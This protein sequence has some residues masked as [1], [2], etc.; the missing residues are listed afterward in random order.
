MTALENV[1]LALSLRDCPTS[2][3]TERADAALVLVTLADRAGQRVSRLS[4]G[5]S[6]RVA[7]AGALACAR[8]LLIADE[9]TSRLDEDNATTVAI[10]LCEAAAEGQ[11]VICAT[12][13]P[14]LIRYAERVVELGT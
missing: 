13:D 8:G 11:T 12:H 2:E 14:D 6:Q 1:T 7:L 10:A 9:P 3:A 4:A 5:E